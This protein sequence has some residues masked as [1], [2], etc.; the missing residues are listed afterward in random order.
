MSAMSLT[1]Q[2]AGVEGIGRRVACF[3]K[4]ACEDDVSGDGN[5]R[6]SGRRPKAKDA[7]G[8]GRPKGYRHAQGTVAF[9]TN[10]KM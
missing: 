8:N 1:T 5:A 7:P 10:I 6:E 4:S 9:V 2:T 3:A